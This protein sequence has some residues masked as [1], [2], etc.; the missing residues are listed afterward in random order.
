MADVQF[1]NVAFSIRVMY[2]TV[3]SATDPLLANP[4]GLVGGSESHLLQKAV[5]GATM[6]ARSQNERNVHFL[7]AANGGFPE[8]TYFIREPWFP[9]QSARSPP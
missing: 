4:D 9:R 2:F 6:E 5:T 3:K 8:G 1:M 7:P